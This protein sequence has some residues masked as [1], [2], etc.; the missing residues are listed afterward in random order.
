MNEF[1]KSTFDDQDHNKLRIYR[2]FKSSFTAEPYLSC[3][4]NRN[5]RSSLTR[6]RISAHCL[7]TE[8]LRRTRPVT[9][10]NQRFCVFCQTQPNTNTNQTDDESN[11]IPIKHL[12]T[13]QHFLLVCNRFPRTRESFLAKIVETRLISIMSKHISIVVVVVV[14]VV[15]K[16]VRFKNGFN[17]RFNVGFQ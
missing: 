2:T 7:A 13:E 6:L 9:P 17:I 3:V 8:T 14:V 10:F 1:K 11:S 12:D 15:K 16:K 4:R 5:Q